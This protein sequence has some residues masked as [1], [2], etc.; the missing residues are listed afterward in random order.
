LGGEVAVGEDGVV[1]GVVGG[2]EDGG[3]VELLGGVDGIGAGWDEVV[4]GELVVAV[5]E[6]GL[7]RSRMGG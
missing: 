4:A 3:L 7:A 5:E 6:V 2:D 1:G